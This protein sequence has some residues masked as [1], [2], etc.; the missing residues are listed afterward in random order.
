MLLSNQELSVQV[1]IERN[2]KEKIEIIKH[3]LNNTLAIRDEMKGNEAHKPYKEQF[4]ETMEKLKICKLR[5]CDL[6]AE[7][8]VIDQQSAGQGAEVSEE[9]PLY[10]A[11]QYTAVPIPKKVSSKEGN[12][13]APKVDRNLK[14]SRLAKSNFF[15]LSKNSSAQ[16][17]EKA[18]K[19]KT[20]TG[21]TCSGQQ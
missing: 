8:K 11:V 14:P 6:K 17:E 4:D 12:S 18:F 10:G 5:I 15:S 7:I 2:L 13:E 21:Y 20:K 19:D 1:E 3:N 9:N 16:K